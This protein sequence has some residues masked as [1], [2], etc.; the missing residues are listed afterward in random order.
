MGIFTLHHL[1]L[2]HFRRYTT[3]STKQELWKKN[4]N[5][6]KKYHN[7]SVRIDGIN[8]KSV[9]FVKKNTKTPYGASDQ[10]FIIL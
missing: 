8:Q 1:E 4:V 2:I 10:N 6:V 3:N 7:S 5:I 9:V